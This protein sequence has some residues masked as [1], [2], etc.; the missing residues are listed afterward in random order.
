MKT[1]SVLFRLTIMKKIEK[2]SNCENPVDTLNP[3]FI[4]V[5]PTLGKKINR[6]KSVR[7]KVPIYKAV[8]METAVFLAKG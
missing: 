8:W 6:P 3:F 1:A 5:G 2:K 7:L 4:K